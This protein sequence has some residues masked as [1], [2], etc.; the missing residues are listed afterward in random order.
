MGGIQTDSLCLWQ[1]WKV[2]VSES[3]DVWTFV[4]VCMCV[5][6]QSELYFFSN[7]CSC[8]PLLWIRMC[9]ES[10]VWL[11][12]NEK[13]H[14]VC[15][16]QTVFICMS[17]WKHVCRVHLGLEELCAP[18]VSRLLF[19][20]VHI[21]GN[22]Y[23][24]PASIL[25]VLVWCSLLASPRCLTGRCVAEENISDVVLSVVWKEMM[26]E[27]KMLPK[28]SFFYLLHLYFSNLRGA[29]GHQTRKDIHILYRRLNL[30]GMWTTSCMIKCWTKT[31]KV[32]KKIL[33]STTRQ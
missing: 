6:S 2:S 31:S 30:L 33:F 25:P 1:L 4:L 11:H 28:D 16:F 5:S 23:T 14:N 15:M 17:Q 22:R 8:R 10:V 24:A 26:T 27:T 20:L 7:I 32:L 9:S 19:H 3:L 13:I 21:K 29:L 12:K 18:P